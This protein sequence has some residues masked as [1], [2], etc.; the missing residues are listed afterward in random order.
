MNLAKLFMTSEKCKVVAASIIPSVIM[1]LSLTIYI[2]QTRTDDLDRFLEEQGDTISALVV[3]LSRTALISG[4]SVYIQASID[5][6]CVREGVRGI[7][8]YR[9]DGTILYGRNVADANPENEVTYVKEVFLDE[10]VDLDDDMFSENGVTSPG[11]T[12]SVEERSV[13]RVLVT[14]GKDNLNERRHNIV[15]DCLIFGGIAL[16]ISA[17]IGSLIGLNITKRLS[18][19]GAL[20][21]SLSRGEYGRTDV[22]RGDNEITDLGNVLN[23]MS[24]DLATVTRER[25]SQLK[26]LILA[27]EIVDKSSSAKTEFL[28][29]ITSETLVPLNNVLGQLNLL[30][31]TELKTAQRV[32]V[33]AAQTH[34]DYLLNLMEDL[35]EFAEYN[36]QE[37]S[38]KKRYFNFKE[39]LSRIIIDNTLA[40][41]DKGL[42]FETEYSGDPVLQD[43]YINSDPIRIRQ[44]I[45]HLISNAIRFTQSGS[46]YIHT[47]TRKLSTGRVSVH[48]EIVDSGIGIDQNQYLELTELLQGLAPNDREFSQTKGQGLSICGV[49]ARKL[50]A[51]MSL[52]P[53]TSNGLVVEMELEAEFSNTMIDVIHQNVERP[54]KEAL[55]HV[56]YISDTHDV[57]SAT[58][59]LLSLRQIHTEVSGISHAQGS[60]IENRY[61]FIFIECQKQNSAM[62][63]LIRKMPHHA[64]T[65]II[66]IVETPLEKDQL[67]HQDE[68]N[69]V[70]LRTVRKAVLY[71]RIND[72]A[73]LKN[74]LN[75]I[76]SPK[77]EKD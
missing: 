34:L 28:G 51:R 23:R 33:E 46:I 54:R 1:F 30:A 47:H 20:A 44:I 45:Q 39:C 9:A 53:A 60:L 68:I 35:L 63:R 42:S 6:L 8:V 75:F 13:G 3:D 62:A 36:Q 52:R 41:T 55:A 26:E 59:Q 57:S 7:V 37:F 15:V 64:L 19:V 2:A 40:V 50:G 25:D 18:K 73:R 31:E 69:E 66:A 38:T 24:V 70:F 21:V 49:L 61:D 74:S 29:N 48:F 32:H 17:L 67:K 43:G 4:N 10:G 72:Y 16:L 14:L 27:S 11:N 77:T 76:Y 58:A 56:L 65:P 71:D 22:F 12:K 5:A